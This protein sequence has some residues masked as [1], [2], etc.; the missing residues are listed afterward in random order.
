MT[1]SNECDC[2]EGLGR[3]PIHNKYG[4]EVMEITCPACNG[5]CEPEQDDV[6]A[7]P[8]VDQPTLW[9]QGQ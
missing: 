5:W 3:Y 1:S 4:Q 7:G 2:C 6:Q 8:A 9:E